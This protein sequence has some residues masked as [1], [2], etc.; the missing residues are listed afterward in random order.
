[1][2]KLAGITLFSLL[3]VGCS[4]SLGYQKNSEPSRISSK[5]P[6][7][8][9]DPNYRD[10]PAKL[11]AYDVNNNG[12]FEAKELGAIFSYLTGRDYPNMTYSLEILEKRQEEDSEEKRRAH[13][14]HLF[15]REQWAANADR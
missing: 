14:F 13:E 11:L 8:R 2:R 4:S 9:E 7:P 1:M 5:S 15:L 6:D 10:L 12:V 3:L